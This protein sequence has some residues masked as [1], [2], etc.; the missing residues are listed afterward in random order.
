MPAAGS[1]DPGFDAPTSPGLAPPGSSAPP[2]MPPLRGPGPPP[3]PP[4]LPPLPPQYAEP[5]PPMPHPQAFPAGLPAHLMPYAYGAEAAPGGPG[6]PFPYGAPA[7][8]ASAQLQAL[9]VD[10]LPA[11]YRIGAGRSWMVRALLALALIGGGVAAA[12]LII[13]SGASAPPTASIVI[14][15]KPSGAA[16]AID[17]K[18]LAE[19]TP[20]VWR[21]TPGARHEIA[22]T[23][24]G[25]QPYRD[26][27]LVPDGGGEVKVLA[28]LPPQTVRLRVTSTPPGADVYL[29]GALKGRTPIE[30]RDLA[31]AS[32]TDVELRLKD[33]APEHKALTWDRDEQAVDFRLR[34]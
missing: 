28:F 18:A 23:L 20:V 22:V 21:T 17:G 11:Q 14:E 2:P 8:T 1:L 3:Q 24:A 10:E 32:A 15:S 34:R 7:P 13:R 25:F 19:V 16:V 33:Y 26:T 29:N 9:E 12:V 5:Y 4:Q 31:P 27:V 6:Y 30:L